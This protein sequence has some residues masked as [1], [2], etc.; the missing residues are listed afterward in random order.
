MLI[1][2]NTQQ[3]ATSQLQCK[4]QMSQEN[5]EFQK[6]KVRRQSVSFLLNSQN[7]LNLQS[8]KS[9]ACIERIQEC[10]TFG[11][12]LYERKQFEEAQ[13]QF[14]EALR[15]FKELHRQQALVN[16]DMKDRQQA[17]GTGSTQSLGNAIGFIAED[18]R[19]EDDSYGE[20]E[21]GPATKSKNED[22]PL[23]FSGMEPADILHAQDS[24]AAHDNLQFSQGRDLTKKL[25]R[26]RSN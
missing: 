9:L 26:S 24:S 22:D 13:K 23:F 18:A 10:K 12:F 1:R 17:Y 25:T 14:E 20:G 8:T 6:A 2:T 15:Q 3:P 19:S 7:L 16:K 5:K 11:K 21:S 4:S